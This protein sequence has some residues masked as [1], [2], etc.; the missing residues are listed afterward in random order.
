MAK[1]A[2]LPIQLAR[3]RIYNVKVYRPGYSL[4]RDD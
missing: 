2:F 4:R 1:K 3:Q